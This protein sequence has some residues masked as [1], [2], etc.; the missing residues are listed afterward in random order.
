MANIYLYSEA[1][2]SFRYKNN[3]LWIFRNYFNKIVTNKGN[4]I[5]KRIS[6]NWMS[7]RIITDMLI[8]RDMKQIVVIIYT[9]WS[10]DKL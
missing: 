10:V 6:W 7:N 1:S 3:D 4:N 5:I 2:K 9:V 8:F